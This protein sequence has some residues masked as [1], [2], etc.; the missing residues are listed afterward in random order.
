L[1]APGT[2]VEER[3]NVSD[4]DELK[5]RYRRSLEA[6]IQ[7]DPEPQK[8]LWSRSG[9]VTLANPFGPPAK[10]LE[11]VFAAMDSAAAAIREAEGLTFEVISS[12]ETPDLAYEVAIQSSKMKLGDSPDMV[13]L[14]L[15]VTTIFRREDDGWKLVHRH[16]DPITEQRPPESLVQSSGRPRSEPAS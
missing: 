1:D 5:E 12:C 14:A 2:R 9:N 13:P 15:R 8:A 6:F 4:L 10:G 16:A 3:I 11:H 7:G